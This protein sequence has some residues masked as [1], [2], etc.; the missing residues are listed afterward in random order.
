MVIILLLNV[1]LVGVV[2]AESSTKSVMVYTEGR[3]PTNLKYNGIDVGCVRVSYYAG[4]STLP[5]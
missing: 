1:I 2:N 3:C 4:C 5:S